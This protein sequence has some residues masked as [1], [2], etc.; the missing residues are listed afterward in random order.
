MVY[1]SYFI[2]AI[3]CGGILN[4]FYFAGNWKLIEGLQYSQKSTKLPKY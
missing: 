4:T 3:K 2:N 1:K